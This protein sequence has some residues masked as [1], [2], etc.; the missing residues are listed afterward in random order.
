[1]GHPGP[2]EEGRAVGEGRP[3]PRMSQCPSRAPL[4]VRQADSTLVL[5][6]LVAGGVGEGIP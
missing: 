4:R 1:M 2:C 5:S 6:F 3:S